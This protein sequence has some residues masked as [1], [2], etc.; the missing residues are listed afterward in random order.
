MLKKV[1]GFLFGSPKTADDIFD[2]DSGLLVK[3]GGWVDGL[4]FSEQERAE[5]NAASMD[6]IR[7]FVVDTLDE[8]TDRSKARRTI[9]QE[10]MRFYILMLFMAGMTYPVNPEWSQVWVALA[11]SLSVG[12]LVTSISVFFFGSHAMAK[13]QK[14]KE[15]V[16]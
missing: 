10:F 13:W 7:K 6:G 14:G 15:P 2:K 16:K 1:A 4:N 12:G 8:N 5:L 9:A 3:A 11:T